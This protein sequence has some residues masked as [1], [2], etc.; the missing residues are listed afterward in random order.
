M[1]T[2]IV[3]LGAL[4]DLLHT[5]PAVEALP[6]RLAWVIDPRWLPLLQGHPKIAQWIPF[7]RRSWPSIQQAWRTMRAQ[8]FDL[9]ID[10][11]GLLK[12]ALVARASGAKYVIGH[13]KAN[14]REPLAR[15][16]YTETRLSKAAHV[17]DRNA[18]LARVAIKNEPV[19]LPKGEP[20]GDLPD[21]PFV[22]A[23]PFAGWRSKQWPLE[24]YQELARRVTLVLNVAPTDVEALKD[25]KGAIIHVSSLQGLLDAT[26]RA[27]AVVGVD[28][29]P[30]HIAAAL[31][32]PGVA[33]FGP[34]D[35]KR[36][37]PY[38]DTMRVLRSPNALTSYRRGDQIDPAM[39]DI[40]PDAVH[41]ELE[42]LLVS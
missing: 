8:T 4:G 3:R 2:L 35:P 23:S 27:A 33:I 39:R 36:N 31:H 5:L 10:F 37:G 17:V 9:A 28:S 11:Q 22:L 34:T 7:D 12:S 15:F 6:G 32:K 19:W 25:I 26:R 41:A 14:L 1:N 38:G 40:T 29:G 13:D 24:Y 21:K 16:L 42:K 30:L 18:D 20:E